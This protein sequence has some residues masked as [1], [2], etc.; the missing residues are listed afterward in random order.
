MIAQRWAPRVGV[1]DR[2]GQ[3]HYHLQFN[4][5][6]SAL[7]A[8]VRCLVQLRITTATE[9]DVRVHCGRTSGPANKRR[10]QR[11]MLGKSRRRRHSIS[12]PACRRIA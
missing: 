10:S 3:D 4:A 9:G 12:T 7:A 6:M 5:T 11:S 1:S 8:V 2:R